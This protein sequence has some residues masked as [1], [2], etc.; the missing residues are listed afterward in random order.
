ME[1]SSAPSK[2]TTPFANSGGVNVIPVPSQ[3]GVTPGAASYT[4]GFPPLTRTPIASGGVPPSGLDMNGIL[5]AAT[6]PAVWYSAGGGFPF[7]GT[8]A[9]AVGGYPKGARVMRTDGTGY[10]LNTAD[11]NSNDPEGST[12]TGW[13]PDATN[14]IAAVAMTS[15]NVT[16]TPAQYGKPIIVISGTLSADLSL[17]FPNIAGM[18]LVAN[19]CTGAYT[20][21]CKTAA[22]TGVALATGVV[23][24]VYG[25]AT[26]INPANPTMSVNWGAPGAIG[27]TTPNTGTFTTLT[28]TTPT[29]GDNTT[30]VATTAFVHAILPFGTATNYTSSGRS[31]GS[32]Y[33]N[34]GTTPRFVKIAYSQPSS[35][36]F[37][38]YAASTSGAASSQIVDVH[39]GSGG[40]GARN[41]SFILPAG[42]YYSAHTDTGG[43]LIAWWEV[44]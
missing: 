20:V 34:T 42:W 44:Q 43:S 7:D 17:I 41:V 39:A 22:G 8:F 18:W 24:S 26:N 12:P 23:E 10:W 2:L 3:I 21:T 35:G 5:Q 27:A 30:N 6:A 25:D 11:N 36:T 32:V 14:G 29:A 40:T 16:L 28:A 13:V 15:A 38:L 1:S 31:L 37:T 9:T 19:N 4:D 33:Q